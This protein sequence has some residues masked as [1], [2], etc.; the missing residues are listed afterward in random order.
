MSNWQG[1]DIPHLPKR[2]PEG[3]YML[4]KA[5]KTTIILQEYFWHAVC[6]M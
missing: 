6:G 2:Q 4:C 1:E 3:N 5:A